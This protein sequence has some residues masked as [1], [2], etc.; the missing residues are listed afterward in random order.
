MMA[1]NEIL[2]VNLVVVGKDV[3]ALKSV[4]ILVAWEDVSDMKSQHGS[5]S[6]YVHQK[7]EG[8]KVS[9]ECNAFGQQGHL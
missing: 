4:F 6:L 9:T 3:S 8:S 2:G 7:Q 5:E 1:F